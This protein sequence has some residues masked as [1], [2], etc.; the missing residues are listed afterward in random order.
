MS[1]DV[2]IICE[3]CRHLNSVLVHVQW[4]MPSSVIITTAAVI[5]SH[6]HCKV[7]ILFSMQTVFFIYPHMKNFSSVRS[8]HLG[9]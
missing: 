1:L 9:G 8:S 4:S 5:V 2:I 6:R 3:P 7:W